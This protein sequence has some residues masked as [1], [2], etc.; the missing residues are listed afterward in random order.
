MNVKLVFLTDDNFVQHLCT[1]AAS[2]ILNCSRPLDIYVLHDGL[3]ETSQKNIRKLEE[4]GNATVS[5]KQMLMDDY[6][7]APACKQWPRLIYAKLNLQEL[8]LDKI[9][10]LDC[11]VIVLDDL[12]KLYDLPLEGKPIGACHSLT[13]RK[14]LEYLGID[15]LDYLNAGMLL[16]DLNECRR[17]DCKRGFMELTQKYASIIK[18]QEQ[19]ILNL[20]FK[21]NWKRISNRWN[22]FNNLN[23]RRI[24]KLAMYDYAM[25]DEAL[26]NPGI[27]HY[28]TYKP[29][30]KPFPITSYEHYYRDYLKYTPYKDYK[31]PTPSLKD[32]LQ[33]IQAKLVL[34]YKNTFY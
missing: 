11:D 21:G 22:L 2:A 18:F 1:A 7:M 33:Y 24:K 25:L 13:S 28:T 5:F 10:L 19:D 4:L 8:P 31:F 16:I 34:A 6:A 32:Y 20:Y 14:R 12:A 26:K 9:I 17:L 29:W 30:N 27:V 3:S 15:P 23:R